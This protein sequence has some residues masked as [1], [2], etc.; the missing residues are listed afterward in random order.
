MSK[1]GTEERGRKTEV[2]R[3]CSLLK[4]LSC[5]TVESTGE[6]VDTGTFSWGGRKDDFGVL[7]RFKI[8]EQVFNPML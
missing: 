4:G 7:R 8:Y 2:L 1:G 6:G 5:R 3:T